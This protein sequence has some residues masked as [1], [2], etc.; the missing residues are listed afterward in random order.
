MFAGSK[1][2]VAGMSRSLA[3][4]ALLLLSWAPAAR[5]AVVFQN[6]GD[7]TGWGR[8]Y[9]QRAGTLTAVASPAYSGS[10]ALKMTQTYQ[11]SDGGNYHAEVVKNMAGLADQDLYYGQALY[12]PPDWV[13]HDQNVTFEQFAQTDVFGSPWVLLYVQRD[14]LF[15]AH[16]VNGSGNTDLG[17]ITGL[18]GTWI[19]LVTRMKLGPAGM[20]EFWVNGEKRATLNGN[21]QAP[22]KGAIRWSVGMYCTYWRREQPKG[23][24]PMVLFHDQMRVATTYAEADPASWEDGAPGV[25]AL[26]GGLDMVA[27]D[28]GTTTIDADLETDAAPA[29][30][31]GAEPDASAMGGRSGMSRPDAA[32]AREGGTGGD[33]PGRDDGPAARKTAAS[34]CA[35][36]DHA[37]SC[38]PALLVMACLGL[39]RR[40]RRR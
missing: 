31:G 8:V 16:V 21:I 33:S 36:A 1:G 2:S 40:A 20:M 12:L 13:F 4:G 24:N 22:N 11:T 9:T 5:A 17:P 15:I 39:C 29:S 14:H 32:P 30:G 25:P 26:D 7:T 10:T 35:F 6:A 38:A 27:S 3:V 37:G 34:G 23:L 18:Q 19:R 28:A